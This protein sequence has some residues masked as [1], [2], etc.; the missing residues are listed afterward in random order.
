MAIHNHYKRIEHE[1]EAAQAKQQAEAQVRMHSMHDFSRGPTLWQSGGGGSLGEA[2]TQ[3]SAARQRQHKL[4]RGCPTS[5]LNP[6]PMMPAPLLGCRPP[7]R[8]PPRQRCSPPWGPPACPTS[9]MCP[10]SC[11][12]SL[13]WRRWRATRWS[14]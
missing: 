1:M 8:Q 11:C 10:P 13:G 14:G 6:A 4:W 2:G 3:Q 7:L 9:P 5:S 12:G